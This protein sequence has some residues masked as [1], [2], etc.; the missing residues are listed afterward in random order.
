MEWSVAVSS[1]SV[2]RT[3]SSEVAFS[4]NLLSIKQQCCVVVECIL[5]RMY[6]C[7]KQVYCTSICMCIASVLVCTCG[8]CCTKCTVLL[9]MRL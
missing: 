2:I 7:L 4:A 1:K 9:F 8:T 3:F 5:L 6:K